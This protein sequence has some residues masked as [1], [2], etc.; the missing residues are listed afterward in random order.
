MI[1]RKPED[2]PDQRG[3]KRRAHCGLVVLA[4]FALLGSLAC[5][6]TLAPPPVSD[7]PPPYVV[8]APDR[9]AI[10][11]LPEPELTL[12]ATVR[13]D[14]MISVPLIGDVEAGGRTVEQI[15]DDIEQRMAKFKRGA[16]VTVMLAAAVHTDITVMGEVIKTSSFPLVR[17]TRVVEAIALVGGPTAFAWNSKIRVIRTMD[18][19]TQVHHVDLTKIRKGDQTT[20]MM[21]K[22]G[23]IVY[24]PPTIL[25]RIGYAINALLFPFQPL[26]GVARVGAA[27]FL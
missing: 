24:V 14:G 25:A 17:D 2:S 27:G 11:V 7:P 26:L 9:L 6:T 19:E 22:P 18:G 3:S 20:N 23:D 4:L 10:E 21:L 5:A 13:P 15:S 12:E 16:Q 1:D 8:G